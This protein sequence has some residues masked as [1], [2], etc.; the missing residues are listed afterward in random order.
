MSTKAEERKK[1]GYWAE[2]L[3][4][5]D[6]PITEGLQMASCSPACKSIA[7]CA[8]GAWQRGWT[9]EQWRQDVLSRHPE[10]EEVRLITAAEDCMRKSGLWLWNH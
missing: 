3:P 6:E 7:V 4:L 9:A 5:W 2:Y 8:A 10:K 1:P